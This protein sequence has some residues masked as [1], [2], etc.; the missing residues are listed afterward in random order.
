MLFDGLSL[1]FKIFLGIAAVL[2]A[3]AL[4]IKIDETIRKRQNAKKAFLLILTL[5]WIAFWQT[6]GEEWTRW[7]FGADLVVILGLLVFRRFSPHMEVM[8]PDDIHALVAQQYRNRRVSSL[9]LFPVGHQ[10]GIILILNRYGAFWLKRVIR[11]AGTACPHCVVE[12]ELKRRT[13]PD[14]KAIA[15]YRKYLADGVAC[16]VIIPTMSPKISILPIR[17]APKPFAPYCPTH[18]ELAR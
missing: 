4:P 11:V 17:N 5:L 3:I 7:L 6:I 13:Q 1:G 15:M 12:T 9:E 18:R 10:R 16:R 2:S 8:D 14:Q